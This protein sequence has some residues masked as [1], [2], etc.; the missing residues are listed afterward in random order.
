M[1]RLIWTSSPT[2]NGACS[3]R[4]ASS[5]AIQKQLGQTITMY[6]SEDYYSTELSDG[7]HIVNFVPRGAIG[8]PRRTLSSFAVSVIEQVRL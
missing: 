2:T 8:N 6:C 7:F 1:A 4:P 5:C 3:V